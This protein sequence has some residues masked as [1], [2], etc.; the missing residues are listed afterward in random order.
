MAA[1]TPIQGGAATQFVDVEGVEEEADARRRVWLNW[2]SPGYF[3]TL[4]TP[5]AEGR[6]F[7]AR[8]EGAAR[9]AIVNQ[10]LARQRFGDGRAIG[11]RL[12]L[13]LSTHSYEIVGVVGD[14]KYESL[15]DAPPPT[16]Y[17]HA[18][19]EAR[20]RV[21]Q[22]ALRTSVP[23]ASIAGQVRRVAQDS[24]QAIAAN[25]VRT[26]ADQ[27]DASIVLERRNHCRIRVRPDATRGTHQNRRVRLQL[28][29]SGATDPRSR[30]QRQAFG[31]APAR[32]PSGDYRHRSLEGL[33]GA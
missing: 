7:S 11:R 1:V 31:C 4:G 5:L 23:P 9:V 22:F 2:V 25:R 30:S 24:S 18:F 12:T 27:L 15:H 16:V 21:S 8:D 13:E 20:G 28:D 29:R 26:L 6:D 3:E 14:A 10:R 33:R 32:F 19:Q 17:L